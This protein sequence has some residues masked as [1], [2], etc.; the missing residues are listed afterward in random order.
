M[1]PHRVSDHVVSKKHLADERLLGEFESVDPGTGA[2]ECAQCDSGGAP[3]NHDQADGTGTREMPPIK[4]DGRLI[5]AAGTPVKN[6]GD[7]EP[8]SLR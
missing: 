8:L 2:M 6:L 3:P 4:S 5:L 7:C 1:L